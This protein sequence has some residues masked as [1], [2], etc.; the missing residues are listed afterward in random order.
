MSQEISFASDNYAGMHPE[1]LDALTRANTGHAPAYGD[2]HWTL[3]LQ[4][5]MRQHFGE[6]AETLPVFNGTGANVIALQSVLPRW[7]A[8]VCPAGAHINVDEG[9]APE[10][11]GGI[12]LMPVASPDGKLTPALIDEQAWGFGDVHRAQPLT[13]SISQV[14]EIG[15]CYTPEELRTL[16][17]HAHGLGMAVHMDGSRLANAAAFLGVSLREITTDVGVDVLSLG[18]TKNGLLGAEAVVVLNPERATG[19]PYLRKT[20]LHLASKM[21]FLSAQ[22]TAMYEGELW[23]RSATHANHMAER[24]A[25]GLDAAGVPGI[26]IVQPVQSNAVFAKLPDTAV[27]RARERFS[28]YDWPSAPGV[29]RLMCAFDT[30]EDDVDELVRLLTV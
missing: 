20:Y 23:I 30:R 19:L 28:F 21:R 27:A 5:V 4:Q 10:T 29:Y 14:T 17:D 6:Q 1:V 3:Y 2:D 12:K 26:E 18:G 22:L 13:V 11:V 15:T 9:G 25:T 16:A 24:L 8:V 7:G